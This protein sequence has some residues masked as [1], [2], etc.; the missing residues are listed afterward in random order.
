MLNDLFDR[1]FKPRPGTPRPALR[2]R[3]RMIKRRLRTLSD[4]LDGRALDTE[5]LRELDAERRALLC[6]RHE[7]EAILR[8][9][10]EDRAA[11]ARVEAAVEGRRADQIKLL[12]AAVRERA[13]QTERFAQK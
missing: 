10:R 9:S 6:D 4:V 12:Q 8:P 7:L 5:R 11:K 2:F 3:L 13:T 1:I